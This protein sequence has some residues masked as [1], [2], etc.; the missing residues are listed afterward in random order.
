MFGW[1]GDTGPGHGFPAR[2]PG[3]VVGVLSA[4]SSRVGAGEG[5]CQAGPSLQGS[6][7][8]HISPELMGEDPP[9]AN[10][11]SRINSDL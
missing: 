7:Q 4:E 10:A 11:I 8:A 9:M 1:F 3:P 6:I 5:E 2:V